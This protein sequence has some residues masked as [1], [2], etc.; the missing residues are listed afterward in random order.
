MDNALKRL[1][2]R[3]PPPAN[4]PF[5]DVNWQQL[6]RFVGL[7]YPTS[8]KEFVEVYGACIWFDHFVPFY[9]LADTEAEA[10]EFLEDV[11][12][13]LK[14]HEPTLYNNEALE[15]F[16]PPI[17][18]AKGGL[19][20]FLKDMYGYIYCWRTAGRNAN[21]WP[22]Y[23]CQPGRLMILEKTTIAK[24]FLDFMEHKSEAVQIWG[25]IR[26][27]DADQI[28]LFHE[29]DPT[30]QPKPKWRKP[31]PERAISR[32]L[33]TGLPEFGSCQK[34]ESVGL[35]VECQYFDD[36][37]RFQSFNTMYCQK[38]LMELAQKWV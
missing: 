6:E 36:A 7:P 25:D 38:C 21:H 4:P 20:P 11:E 16:D 9:S 26:G 29:R 35:V 2:K 33:K 31:D 1:M 8:F 37:N 28:R 5:T 15:R 13:Y 22:V 17:Y 32:G 3:M 30:K 10:K 27:M 34:C 14:V 18:P 12:R 23:C 19:F 24:M